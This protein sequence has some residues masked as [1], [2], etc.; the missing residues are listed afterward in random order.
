MGIMYN[1]SIIGG[2]LMPRSSNQKMKV[3]YIAK[4]LSERTDDDNIMTAQD[5]IEALS[6]YDISSDRKSIYDDIEALRTFGYDIELIPGKGGGYYLAS[7]DFELAELK[8]LVDA[9]ES[10]R[11]ITSKKSRELI[12]KLSKLTSNTQAKHLNRQVYL[13][14]RS[15]ALN[16]SV[17]YNIDAIHA[18]INSGNQISFKYFSYNIRKNRVYRHDE[19]AYVR[20]PVAMCWNEDKYYLI[21]YNPKFD[22]PFASYRVD[23]MASVEILD[24]V[25]DKY[26]KKTFNISEYI[27]QNFGMF[28][29]E[30]VRAKLSFDE[31]LV[32][33]VLDYFGSD[34]VLFDTGNGRFTINVDVTGSNV[35]LGW[36]FQFGDLVEI[37]EPTSLRK[38]MKGMIKTIG[39]IYK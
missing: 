9:V 22:D 20:T 12:R 4:I 18:A 5:I 3:L 23:R 38:S 2:E 1:Q 37:L 31:S 16:E 24:V 29:G 13:S 26:D 10:S 11:L 28:S 33:V 15:K 8:L 17:Y 30:T 32:S 14:H 35:F 25:A 7:R 21:T 36:I 6:Y 27:K 34:T 39:D 19:K